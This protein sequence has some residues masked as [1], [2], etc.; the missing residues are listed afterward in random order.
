MKFT[1]QEISIISQ[2]S[3]LI[4]YKPT[5]KKPKFRASVSVVLLFS[6]DRGGVAEWPRRSTYDREVVDS[7]MVGTTVHRP[8]VNSGVHTFEVGTRVLRVFVPEY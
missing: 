8:T 1:S 3:T 2:Q 4:E 7:K 5:N 6:P